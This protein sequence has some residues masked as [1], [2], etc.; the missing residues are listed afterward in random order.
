MP[1]FEI[2]SSFKNYKI[3]SMEIKPENDVRFT[4]KVDEVNE[5]RLNI[6][7]YYD[8]TSIKIEQFIVGKN[9]HLSMPVATFMP[10]Q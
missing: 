8:V 5:T 7:D 6:T 3:T 4:F 2:E 10:I 9:K 1:Q